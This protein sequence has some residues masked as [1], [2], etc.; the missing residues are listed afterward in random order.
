M[1]ELQ[2]KSFEFKIEDA[3]SSSKFGV[4]RGLASAFGNIDLGDDVIEKGAFNQTIKQNKGK[5]P[6]LADHNPYKQIGWNL[7]AE[8]TDAG[9]LVEGEID[10][11]NADGRNKY[12]LA[13]KAL[14]IGAQM[15]LSIGYSVVKAIADKNN[16]RV[17]RL[18]ELKLYEYS[19]VTFPMNT[20]AMVQDVKQF[21]QAM[22]KEDFLNIVRSRA[23]ELGIKMSDISEFA[24]QIEAA[25]SKDEPPTK[26]SDEQIIQSIDT[27]IARIKT[28]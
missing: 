21:S 2:T 27:L 1:K 24:L 22:N 14:E 25:A 13:K 3:D 18:K 5:F 4:I 20:E 12:A 23:K 11:E 8:E 17:R 10:L 6:I 16:P 15:G 9:L 7:Q 28:K 19:I 26:H